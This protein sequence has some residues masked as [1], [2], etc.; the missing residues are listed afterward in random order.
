MK[1]II[2]DDTGDLKVSGGTLAVGDTDAQV[3]ELVL[4]ANPGELKE[5]PT[6]G[7]AAHRLIAGGPD[8]WWNAMAKTQLKAVG[9]EVRR[10][11]M[12]NGNI[13]ID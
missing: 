7:C 2:F 13:I 6:I 4:S 10:V 11:A 1:G 3:A 12:E 9:L 8:T 5:I